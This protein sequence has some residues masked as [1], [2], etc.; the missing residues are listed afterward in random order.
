MSS[1]LLETPQHLAPAQI[2]L[3]EGDAD[4]REFLCRVLSAEYKVEL[5]VTA[6]EAMAAMQRNRPDL[7]LIDVVSPR[8]GGAALMQAM[9]ASEPLRDIPIIA[10]SSRTRS[11]LHDDGL[12]KGADDFLAKP[13]GPAE[14]LARVSVNLH[15][16]Q[17]RL[18]ATRLLR[19]EAKILDIL[20]KVGSAVAAEVDLD[21][22]AQV[23]TDA[24]TELSRAAFGAFFYNVAD[25]KGESYM[26]HA[27][28]GAARDAFAGFP[29]PRNTGVFGPSFRGEGIVRSADIT[30]DSRY[31]HNEP[32]FGIPKG[33]P[34]LRSYLAVPVFA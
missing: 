14:L 22:A 1:S 6:A 2:L 11:P 4:A 7:V 32:H 30:A 26:L 8:G 12:P 29:M 24:A 13:V 21:R 34:P 31:G 23:V 20:N 10:L 33:H 19:E 16:A 5:V 3:V 18:H 15:L 17:T 27:L 25:D 28:S 9:R